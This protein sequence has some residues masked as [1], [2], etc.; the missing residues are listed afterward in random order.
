M[1]VRIGRLAVSRLCVPTESLERVGDSRSRSP[2]LIRPPEL[3]RT[4]QIPPQAIA[5]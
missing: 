3:A 2:P 1:A 5:D 4:D